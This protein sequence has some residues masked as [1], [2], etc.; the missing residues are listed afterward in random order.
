MVLARMRGITLFY[1]GK[2][3]EAVV[4]QKVSL[5]NSL[6]GS[7]ESDVLRHHMDQSVMGYTNIAKTLWSIGLADQA[8]ASA[9][10]GLERAR[11]LKQDFAVSY[12]LAY[13]V[14]RIAIM[15]G[16]YLKAERHIDELSE[17]SAADPGL[18]W[19]V[20]AHCWKGT[21]LSRKGDPISGSD[22]LSG[23][24]R[25]VPE[26]SFALHHT[27]FL[28]ELGYAQAQAG[29]VSTGL[30]SIRRAIA[31][32]DR[33]DERWFYVELLRLEGEILLIEGGGR[34]SAEALVKFDL[35]LNLAERQGALGF[36][37]RVAIS[38]ARLGASDGSGRG[39]DQLRHTYDQFT[40]GFATVDLV[41]AMELLNH[42]ER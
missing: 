30:A 7:R 4:H 29:D 37:L 6:R 9:E 3:E 31:I 11:S 1:R 35:A 17:L 32:C 15:T 36:K 34:S 16:E 42:L 22:H 12:A 39:A 20:F 8:T 24:L 40:E 19:G 27:R 14:C 38:L 21:L 25:H 23:A 10:S 5:A 13:A 2:F 26:G 18:Q 33:L 41:E 28:G